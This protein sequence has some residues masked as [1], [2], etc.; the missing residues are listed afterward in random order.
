MTNYFHPNTGVVIVNIRLFRK[1]ELY[2][3]SVFVGKSY[4][5]FKCPTQDIL[6]TVANYKFQYIPLNFNIRLY[7]CLE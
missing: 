6:I 1:D 4:N 3:K 2:K 5:Y 7:S